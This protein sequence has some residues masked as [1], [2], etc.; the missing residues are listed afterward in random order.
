MLVR[1][2]ARAALASAVHRLN[3]VKVG[4]RI[5]DSRFAA[6]V[7][8]EGPVIA[9]LRF[10]AQAVVLANEYVGRAAYLWGD[11]DPRITAVV[12]AVVR[13]GDTA[14]DIGANFGLPG[15]LIAKCVGPNGAVHLFEP[16][17][18]VASCLRASLLINGYSNAVVHECALSDHNGSAT[19]TISDPSDMSTATLS[20]PKPNSTTPIRSICIR[21]ENA[22][23][24]VVSLG[25]SKVALI[26][27]DVEGHEAVIFASM[28]EWLA[29]VR[30]PVILFECHLEGRGFQEQESVRILS[31]LGYEFFNI[32]TKPYWHTRLNAMTEG[33]HEYGRDFVAILWQE[34]DAD[35]R[36]ALEAMMVPRD[37]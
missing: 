4:H 32:D 3:T 34:L 22:G 15:L 20:P 29:E 37:R 28:R 1:E 26:K 30:P 31:G 11:N 6:W 35:R 19:M 8:G 36:N 13:N 10:G 16:Q 25:C 7:C 12:G 27:I 23:N 5:S 9:R 24:Y 33:Q 14:L 2:I 21:T 17:P 18:V